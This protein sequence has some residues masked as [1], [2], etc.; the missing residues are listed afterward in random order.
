MVV[1]NAAMRRLMCWNKQVIKPQQVFEVHSGTHVSTDMG[2]SGNSLHGL[3]F[4][5]T[6]KGVAFLFFH[7]LQAYIP[8]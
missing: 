6:P 1:I 8:V 2:K 7:A 3:L 5:L 4:K